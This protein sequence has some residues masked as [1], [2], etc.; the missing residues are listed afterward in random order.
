MQ[1]MLPGDKRNVKAELFPM[2]LNSGAILLKFI[3]V[4]PTNFPI[5]VTVERL[6]R[7]SCKPYVKKVG[8]SLQRTEIDC[9][10]EDLCV[11]NPTAKILEVRIFNKYI[12][13]LRNQWKNE[14]FVAEA[15]ICNWRGTTFH[16][17]RKIV[18][19]LGLQHRTRSSY[20]SKHSPRLFDR[21]WDTGLLFE[22]QI[23][24]VWKNLFRQQAAH[25]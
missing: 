16:V 9:V 19:I 8:I 5:S 21:I 6:K 3:L 17:S 23:H 25:L 1:V 24:D 10:H 22:R 7:C 18:H 12:V 13:K 15:R 14:Y 4:N 2:I 11:V 20:N